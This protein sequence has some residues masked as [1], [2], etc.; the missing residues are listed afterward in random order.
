MKFV[1]LSNRFPHFLYAR[2]MPYLH[3]SLVCSYM[4]QKGAILFS[5]SNLFRNNAAVTLMQYANGKND[6]IKNI[7]TLKHI[8][9]VLFS[10]YNGNLY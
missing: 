8:R 2:L 9:F 6:L 4:E 1:F 10:K 3:L 7:Y 5:F